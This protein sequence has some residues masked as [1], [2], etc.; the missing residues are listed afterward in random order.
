MTSASLK[1]IFYIGSMSVTAFSMPVSLWLLSFFTI[2][3]VI[4][5]ILDDGLRKVSLLPGK[6]NILIFFTIYLVYVIWMLNTSDVQ[7]GLAELRLQLPFLVFPLVTGLSS[8]LNDKE[9]KIIISAFILGVIVA[10]VYGVIKAGGAVFSGLA[11]S[12]SLS[13]FISHIRLALMVVFGISCSGWFLYTQPGLTRWT[14]FFLISGAWMII[15][16]FLLFSLTGIVVFIVILVISVYIL[17]CRS[18]NWKLRFLYP[19]VI[20]FGF[21]IVFLLISGEV[22]SFYK[23]G[24][25]YPFPPAPF[26]ASG[27][28]YSNDMTR[29]DIE[30][31]NRVW[32]YLCENE[33]KKEW[34]SRGSIRYDSLDGAGQE[35]RYTI[36]RYMTS[37]G[38]KKDS[39]GVSKLS[40]ADI[41]NIEGGMTNKSFSYWSPWKKKIYEIIWQIDYYRNG[42][43]PSRHS[44]TQRLE[45]FKTGWQIF[46]GAPLL[47]IGTGDI[48]KAYS[49]QYVTNNSV[50]EPE[51]RLLCH[52]QF[53]TFLI[54]FGIAGTLIICLVMFYPFYISG[55]FRKY[56][57]SVFFIIVI[58]SMMSEDTLETHT[59][60]T[61][62]A[63]FYSL[64]IFGIA[65]NEKNDIRNKDDDSADGG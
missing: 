57:P 58:L 60:I 19:A 36:I 23:P 40:R 48:S 34:N 56:L 2:L 21:I 33:L 13:P 30:N 44:L 47:G 1:R 11:D 8:P 55:G 32:I 41:S 14:L 35:L 4:I 63:Y 64:F 50:L 26:T 25:A 43:N 46:L 9:I 59:G 18:A 28:S 6:K 45:F 31:G 3:T 22:R 15:Y 24:T 10:S 49:E 52:N 27:G 61:F 42:G 54:S 7:S 12:S 5:W 38:L 65:T 20:L 29:K 39:A 17:I 62:F 51:F 16:L 37:A 53:L